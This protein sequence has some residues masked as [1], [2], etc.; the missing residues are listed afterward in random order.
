MHGTGSTSIAT[1]SSTTPRD[2]REGAGS[3]R[4]AELERGGAAYEA[5]TS[6]EAVLM[7]VG[8]NERTR[9][10]AGLNRLQST[11]PSFGAATLIVHPTRR[12]VKASQ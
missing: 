2:S 9:G 12:R 6:T 3:G 10:L 4:R 7:L 1:D 8:R 5:E 11:R